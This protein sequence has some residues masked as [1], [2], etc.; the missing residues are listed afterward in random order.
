M[1]YFFI[2]LCVIINLKM[3]AQAPSKFY[4][5]FGGNGYDVGYDV[6][7]TLDSGYIIGNHTKNNH[8]P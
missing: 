4:Q 5:R 7:Q 3:S 2:F 1:K 8:L 6:K